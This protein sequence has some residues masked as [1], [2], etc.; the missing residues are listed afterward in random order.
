MESSVGSCLDGA[1]WE[2]LDSGGSL[3]ES[4]WDSCF[5]DCEGLWASSSLGM[6]WLCQGS[7][8]DGWEED[9]G[10]EWWG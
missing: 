9:T 7:W 8:E 6:D 10:E 1:D 2:L 3:W 5:T 4:E